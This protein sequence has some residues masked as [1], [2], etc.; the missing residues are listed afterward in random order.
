LEENKVQKFSKLKIGF[1]FLDQKWGGVY[2]GGNYFIIGSKFAGK[3]LLALKIIENFVISGFTTVLLSNQRTK[4]LEIQAASLSFYIEEPIKNERLLFLNTDDFLNSLENVKNL[5]DEK[6]PKIFVLDNVI[7]N[8]FINSA[9]K[10][11]QLLEILEQKN[12]TLF[13]I[14][15]LPQNE[16]SKQL[17]KEIIQ[18]STGI[19][20]L[21]KSSERRNYSGQVTIKPNVGHIEGEFETNYKVDPQRGFI[22]LADNENNLFTILSKANTEYDELTKTKKF[23]YSN[24]YDFDEFK[25]FIENKKSLIAETKNEMNLIIYEIK[26]GFAETIE[27]CKTLQKSLMLGDKISCKNKTV[28]IFPKKNSSTETNNLI[29]QL[30]STI[31]KNYKNISKI[32]NNVTVKKQILSQ[33]FNF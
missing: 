23:E 33:D 29:E 3:T 24:I 5:I 11:L 19:I 17:L 8:S 28:F 6:N 10:Y 13:S 18:Y 26:N 9:E 32:E 20:Q 21:Q 12:I 22:T 2:P 4:N 1:S 15:S 25:L 27:L 16:N 30:N 7:G 14:S 31:E